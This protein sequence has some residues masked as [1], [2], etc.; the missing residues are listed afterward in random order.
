MSEAKLNAETGGL[1]LD[2][3]SVAVIVTVY[4]ILFTVAFSLY[5]LN[6]A[7][8]LVVVDRLPV[9]H[10][11]AA[12]L[13]YEAQLA[14]VQALAGAN[15]QP[16]PLP[17]ANP[18]NTPEGLPANFVAT[19]SMDLLAF[20]ARK[21]ADSFPSSDSPFNKTGAYYFTLGGKPVIL[22]FTITEC[23]YCDKEKEAFVEATSRFG[24]W[25]GLNGSNF[26]GASFTSQQITAMVIEADTAPY[27]FQPVFMDNSPR[28]KVPLLVFSG[29]YKRIGST[30]PDEGIAPEAS[31][32]TRTICL[33]LPS[34]EET[35]ETCK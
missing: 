15:L 6:N 5:T 21:P 1:R 25:Q 7:P 28:S 3:A 30:P 16:T 2:A 8:M 9:V 17:W 26:S 27:L 32:I 12:S 10:P 20:D 24:E 14:H 4:S 22:L 19:W 33:L 29:V 23:A 13:E 34:G 18:Q 11:D 35:P 31:S